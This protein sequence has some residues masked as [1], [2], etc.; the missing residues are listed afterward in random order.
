[1]PEERDSR[2]MACR[3]LTDSEA[4]SKL[5]VVGREIEGRHL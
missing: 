3:T 4:T 1:M 5:E 2:P